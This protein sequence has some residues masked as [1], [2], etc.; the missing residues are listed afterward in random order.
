M[1]DYQDKEK[2]VSTTFEYFYHDVDDFYSYLFNSNP[3]PLSDVVI[4]HRGIYYNL[5]KVIL[6]V[7]CEYFKTC[8]QRG[9]PRE[10]IIIEDPEVD[11]QT[12][13]SLV[14]WMY[15][16]QTTMSG[17]TAQKALDLCQ[18]WGIRFLKEA[19]VRV[20]PYLEHK[21]SIGAKEM[22][23]RNPSKQGHSCHS[24]CDLDL[25]QNTLVGPTKFV[26][27]KL[28]NNS[29][30]AMKRLNQSMSHIKDPDISNNSSLDRYVDRVFSFAHGNDKLSNTCLD[31]HEH[32]DK[33]SSKG[34]F[35]EKGS[36]SIQSKYDVSQGEPSLRSTK[37]DRDGAKFSNYAS[38][39][40]LSQLHIYGAKQVLS[41]RVKSN[42]KHSR[43]D[44]TIDYR[45]KK[46]PTN[47]D[48]QYK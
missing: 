1:N 10:P 8:I 32:S 48:Y 20:F 13:A 39:E 23:Q 42:N 6:S 29:R 40:L 46:T 12:L 7:H 21:R 17:A 15:T 45:R 34:V 30:T 22:S 41:Q 9:Q 33:V 24:I 2:L 36:V 38:T 18:K 28:K 43:V 35:D 14:E 3:R 5:H 11:S 27:N 25:N 4:S 37:S 47:S 19:I 26:R 44:S 31:N 16:K